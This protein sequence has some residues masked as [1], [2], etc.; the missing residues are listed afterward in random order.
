MEINSNNI[1]SNNNQSSNFKMNFK[2]LN[3]KNHSLRQSAIQYMT[4]YIEEFI[5]KNRRKKSLKQ[6]F[7]DHIKKEVNLDRLDELEKIFDDLINK[8]IID[9]EKN[10]KRDLTI[11]GKAKIT[12]NKKQMLL[13][14]KNSK[15]NFSGGE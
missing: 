15:K 12:K 1:L 3:S 6:Y 10:K 13:T 14:A 2:R 4:K 11:L 8:I 5:K 7:L 9:T